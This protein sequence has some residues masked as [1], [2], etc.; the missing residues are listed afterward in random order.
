MLV[1]FDHAA[2]GLAAGV[3]FAEVAF[4]CGYADQSHMYRDVV[5]FTGRTPG[6]LIG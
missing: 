4:A 2:A 1:R 3:D 5:S 6:A